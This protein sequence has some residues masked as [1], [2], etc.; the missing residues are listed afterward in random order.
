M[1]SLDEGL[2]W[3]W[4]LTE[5]GCPGL[6]LRNFDSLLELAQGFEGLMSIGQQG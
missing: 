4:R 3:V 6:E 2:G 5:S 1:R